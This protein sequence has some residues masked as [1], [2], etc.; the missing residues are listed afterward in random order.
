MKR[1]IAIEDSL[2]DV[3]NYLQQKGYAVEAL[4]NNNNLNDYDAIVVTGQDSNTLGMENAVTKSR[5]INAR[6]Q[7]A[8]QIYQQI[9]NNIK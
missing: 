6:G 2:S 5:V 9:E 1:K 4:Q 3:K 7:T 8:E